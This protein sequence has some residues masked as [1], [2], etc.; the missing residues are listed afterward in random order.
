VIGQQSLLQAPP[1]LTPADLELGP[2]QVPDFKEKAH[3]YYLGG[4]LMPGVTGILEILANDGLPWWGMRCGLHAAHAIV[5][6]GDYDYESFGADPQIEGKND[7][8]DWE[9]VTKALKLDV[10]N[11]RDA[12]GRRGDQ[13]HKA[14]ESWVKYGTPF[15]LKTMTPEAKAYVQSAAGIFVH[16]DRKAFVASEIMVWSLK[17]W[18]AGTFDLLAYIDGKLTMLD[19]K[20]SLRV[21]DKHFLQMAAYED[22][23]RELKLDWIE[24]AGVLH[25]TPDG[26]WDPDT[27]LHMIDADEIER[28]IP[29]WRRLKRVADDLKKRKARAKAGQIPVKSK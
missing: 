2:G 25:L 19:L 13:A 15:D 17:Q 4:K 9:R 7:V 20:T 29:E 28:T 21:Y 3:R 27:H 11:V 12:A 10:N 23:R 14:A 16:F 26:K 22:A 8:G 1:R 6:S 5:Q 18:Y 24:Q